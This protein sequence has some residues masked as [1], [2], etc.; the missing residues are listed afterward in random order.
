MVNKLIY[1]APTTDI[2]ELFMA[3]G[4]AKTS[5]V[6]GSSGENFGWD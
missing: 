4:I 2:V 5:K 6:G 1:S 3:E